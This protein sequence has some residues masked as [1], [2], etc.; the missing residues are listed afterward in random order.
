M[1]AMGQK[2]RAAGLKLSITVLLGIAG[3]E[4]SQ[5]HAAETGRVLSEID[6]RGILA[7]PANSAINELVTEAARL[8]IAAECRYAAIEYEP[9]PSVRLRG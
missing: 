4:R 5:I 3:P 7:T 9:E 8:S 2:A 6:D 1:I